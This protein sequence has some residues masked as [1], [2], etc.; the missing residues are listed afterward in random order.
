MVVFTANWCITAYCLIVSWF[1]VTIFVFC[2][3][4]CLSLHDMTGGISPLNRHTTCHYFLLFGYT[5]QPQS[6]MAPLSDRDSFVFC[7]SSI[8]QILC[9]RV[10]SRSKYRGLGLHAP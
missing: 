10:Q 9:G 2:V 8:I 3:S 7:P 4:L 1:E 6:T 5:I